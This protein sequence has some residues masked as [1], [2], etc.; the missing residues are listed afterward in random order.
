M[1]CFFF[2]LT[3]IKKRKTECQYDLVGKNRDRVHVQRERKQLERK[4]TPN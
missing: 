2:F 4:I 1:L 3:T